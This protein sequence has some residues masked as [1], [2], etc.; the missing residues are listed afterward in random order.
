MS[1]MRNWP[2]VTTI[3]TIAFALSPL[4]RDIFYGA[5]ISGEQLAR[6]L[7]QFILI[8]VALIVV[9]LVVAECLFKWMWRRRQAWNR[10]DR[11][12]IGG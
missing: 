7:S 11:G 3:A 8:V 10:L 6:S 4:G 2:W 1:R 5:F 12:A 9:A